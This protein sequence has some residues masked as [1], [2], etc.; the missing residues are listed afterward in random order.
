MVKALGLP[1]IDSPNKQN[2]FIC[3]CAL[4]W[5]I[6]VQEFRLKMCLKKKMSN[7]ANK[8]N[9]HNLILLVIRD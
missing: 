6:F 8:V 2:V 4:F 7:Y 9:C 5:K 1:I 3:C